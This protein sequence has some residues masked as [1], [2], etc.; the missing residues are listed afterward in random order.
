LRG[1]RAER[2]VGRPDVTGLVQRVRVGAQRGGAATGGIGAG[3]PGGG[4]GGFAGA[5]VKLAGGDAC[6]R[7]LFERERL[8]VCA[9]GLAL[10][11]R[12]LTGLAEQHPRVGVSREAFDRSLGDGQCAQAIFPG[13]AQVHQ[14]GER[15]RERR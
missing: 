12:H 10:A 4:V 8:L 11:K 13:A 5:Q 15:F 6:V 3:E 2:A 14:G 1:Q 9:E 7:A